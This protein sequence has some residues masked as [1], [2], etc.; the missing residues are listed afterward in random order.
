MVH[1]VLVAPHACEATRRALD[2]H[3][4]LD[5]STRAFKHGCHIALPLS[6]IAISQLALAEICGDC[7]EDGDTSLL[8]HWSGGVLRATEVCAGRIGRGPRAAMQ[9]ACAQALAG[10]P[11]EVT[12]VLLSSDTLPRRWEKLGDIVL[13]APTGL[14]DDSDSATPA[15]AAVKKLTSDQRA[16]LWSVLAE[17]VGAAR[18]GVQSR[19]ETSLHRKSTARLLWPTAGA[20]GWT[21]HR[22]NGITY[23]LDVTRNMFSSGNGTEKAR[24]ARLTCKGETVVDL[25][26]GIGYFSL[27]YLVHAGA[28]HLHACEWDDDAVAALRHNLEA[29]GVAERCTVYAGDNA[30]SLPAFR[31]MAH[32]VNLGLIPSSEAGWPVAIAALRPEGGMLH[33]HANVSSDVKQEAAWVEMLLVRLRELS[34]EDGRDWRLSLEHLERVKWYAPHIRHVVADVRCGPVGQPLD[35]LSTESK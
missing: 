24:V 8:L 21:L 3:G 7:D 10:C 6:Q 11:S 32:R 20:S 34:I 18:L 16:A 23:G 17:S 31:G 1:V 4:L 13:F 25:Y 22:E 14:F 9:A 2:E 35:A 26:A 12:I 33:V 29:N 27:G 30:A 5:A 28:A 15:A 19:I